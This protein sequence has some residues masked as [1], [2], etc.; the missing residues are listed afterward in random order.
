LQLTLGILS[1]FLAAASVLGDHTRAG[2]VLAA[3]AARPGD[4]VLAAL[5]LHMDSGW[6][7]Y[8]KNPGDSGMATTIKW[9]LPEGITA[10][11]IQW[12]IPE[13]L[14]EAELTTYVYTEN[15]TLLVP[16]KLSPD[17]K[18][19]PLDIKA[20]LDWLECQ[21]R[22]VPGGTTVQSALTI[23]SETRPSKDAALFPAWQKRL[24]QAGS[25][26]SARA[27]WAKAAAGDTR[28]LVMEWIP[29]A[30]AGEADFYPAASEEFEV[31]P[32]VERVPAEAGKIRI[33]KE[34][35]KLSD[36]WPKEIS[37]LLVQQTGAEQ[38]AYEVKL[39]V[40]LPAPV[41]AD[42]SNSSPAA[43]A[44]LAALSLWKMLLYAFLGGL[45]LNVMPCVLPVIA[46]KILGFVAQA[47]DEPRQVRKL[48]LIYAL[49]VAV[50]FLA[51]AALVIGVKAAGHNAGW[52][53]QFG[54]PKFIIVMAVLVTLVA[55]NLFGLFEVNLS[56]GVMGA[57][58][59]LASKHG[60][61]GAFFNGVLATVLATPC[62]APFL[63]I[64][65]GFAIAQKPPVIL[66]TFFTIG[67]G[68]AL[69]YVVLSWHPAWLKLLPKPGAWMEKFKIAMGFP[70][71][72]TAIWLASI[73][74]DHYGQRAWWFGI[75]LVVVAMA[76]WVFGQFVQRG[77][78]RRGLAA[79]II[80]A[81]LAAG[82]V[83]VLEGRL[84]WRSPAATEN[85]AASVATRSGVIAWQPWSPQAVA[86]A[87]AQR[88]PILVDFTARWC[89][90]CNGIV[91]PALET[92]AIR[93]ALGK[94]NA[95]ALLADYT[96][97][98]ED[99]TA[100]LNRYGR[101][102]VPLVLV[103]PKNPD[104]PA[105]VLPDPSPLRAPSHYTTVVLEALDRAAR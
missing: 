12:P 72:A 61:A 35:K 73:L 85:A 43:G 3:D 36:D 46:L 24:P 26:L 65:L 81:L 78:S 62:T 48:G 57:A 79:L 74:P 44:A 84:D 66:L 99:M 101:A 96:R 91:K 28:P 7:T 9:T 34:V 2:L 27:W 51:L 23:G 54:N 53:M 1:F 31:Q 83:L 20:R 30:D 70:M 21:T 58:G 76:A 11:E 67:L 8:W 13:K 104:A 33:R 103:Y 94:L 102:G 41:S 59:N 75:F 86:D 82:Y 49:G 39:P 37:G 56:G 60:P 90:T 6:H 29:G 50:S 52:G 17:L 42:A 71:L 92:P 38:R 77:Q 19:G 87:R 16:L 105:I 18:P 55:L 25:G 98:P 89:V 80:V 32:A 69:P 15:A 40:G 45:I 10:G 5:T 64:A 95:V 4:T 93:E 22:C 47:K 100:E 88:R 68:L 97:T 63:S 14:P